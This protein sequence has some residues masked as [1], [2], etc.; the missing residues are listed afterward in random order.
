[1]KKETKYYVSTL[2]DCSSSCWMGLFD[3]FAYKEGASG[4]AVVRVEAAEQKGLK[5]L[6]DLLQN[7]L[8]LVFIGYNPSIKS[9]AVGHRFAHHSNK[10]WKLGCECGLF[11]RGTSYKDDLFLPERRK[12][13]FT[14]LVARPT[15]SIRQLSRPEIE[16]NVP[17]LI[18]KLSR[19]E[20]KIVCLVGKGIW[21]SFVRY[22]RFST[23]KEFK[24][25]LQDELI[26]GIIKIFVIPSTSGLVRIS[27]QDMLGYWKQLFRLYSVVSKSDICPSSPAINE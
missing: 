20:P 8:V 11:P 5:P 21:D 17:I 15:A 23:S 6:R 22:F 1:M 18:D 25:G 2:A 7:D 9:S 26:N 13:G 16:E 12:I 4:G 10:F 24:Y 27:Y 3:R 14:D 19:C